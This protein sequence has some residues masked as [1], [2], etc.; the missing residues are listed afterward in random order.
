MN[1]PRFKV[2]DEVLIRLCGDWQRAI[3]EKVTH[4]GEAVWVRGFR[5][6]ANGHRAGAGNYYSSTRIIP[7]DQRRLD[8]QDAE[9]GRREL[10][11]RA[12]SAIGAPYNLRRL[13]YWPD[14]ALNEL[15]ALCERNAPKPEGD[16]S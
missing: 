10:L 8:E 15:I 4:K 6:R 16:K 12:N 11:S 14:E 1:E 5:F 3:V 7:F 13:E 9:K 2:G